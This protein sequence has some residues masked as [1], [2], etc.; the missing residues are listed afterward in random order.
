MRIGTRLTFKEERKM[1]LYE[2][3]RRLPLTAK[4][5]LVSTTTRLSMRNLRR[6]F[7][8]FINPGDLVFDIGAHV[9][10]YTAVFLD[11]GARVV[12]VEP[13]AKCVV[14][15]K[16]RYGSNPDLT[17]VEKGIGAAAGSLPLFIAENASVNATFSAAWVRHPR[18]ADRSWRHQIM[19]PVITLEGLINTHGVPDFCKIDVEGFEHQV[20][21]GLRKPLPALSFEFDECFFENI[22]RCVQR[23]ESL[24]PHQYNYA[25]YTGASLASRN[26]LN[27]SALLSTLH[28][29]R[30]GF[31]RGDIYA[32]PLPQTLPS[33]TEIIA[34][35]GSASVPV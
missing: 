31:L 20:L 32:R 5:V 2:I 34:R 28:V 19:K 16:Q 24:A 12:A 25:L 6:N 9:G 29:S 14:K 26:W 13:Q 11:L 27:A 7:A 33:R 35:R 15:M 8:A 30:N 17:I 10:L 1:F 4:N 23:L 22:A 18:L 21:C 3:Y